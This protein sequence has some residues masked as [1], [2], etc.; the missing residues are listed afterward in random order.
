VDIP[1]HVE[2]A[3]CIGIVRIGSR[4]VFEMAGLLPVRRRRSAQNLRH[5]AGALQLELAIGLD[6]LYRAGE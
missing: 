1:R 3:D 5:V 2:R 6:P 4:I